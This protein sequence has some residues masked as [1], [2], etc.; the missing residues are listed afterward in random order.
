MLLSVAT[1]CREPIPIPRIDPVLHAWDE[2]YEGVDGLELHVFDTGTI[3]VPSA[4]AYRGGSWTERID[5]SVPAFVIEHPDGSLVVF[6]TGLSGRVH[7]EPERY[8]GALLRQVASFSMDDGAGLADQMRAAGLD[9]SHV[10][11]VVVSHLH[12]DHVGAIGDFPGAALVVARRERAAA[13]EAGLF[14]S[15]SFRPEDWS[16]VDTWLEVDYDQGSPYATFSAHHDL[17]GDGSVVL[18]DLRG[19]TAGSQ[20]AVVRTAGAPV[21][22]AGDAVAVEQSWRFAARPAIA[23]EPDQWWEQIWRIKK[24]ADRVPGAVIVPGHDIAALSRI[25]HVAI[26]L[27]DASAREAKTDQ[28]SVE[29]SRTEPGAAR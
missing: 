18:V 29:E 27:H 11:Y 4:I 5:L 6:D 20:G 10:G 8:L 23:E 12:L 9:P 25:D 21:L 1:A 26:S 7:D 15:L 2:P 19:H 22:L 16:G 13:L 17:L 28:E 24:F 3:S 14:H